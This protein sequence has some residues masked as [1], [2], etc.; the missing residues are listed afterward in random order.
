V[1]TLTL[2]HPETRTCGPEVRY[3][4]SRRNSRSIKLEGSAF[5]G[6]HQPIFPDKAVTAE[7]PNVTIM[8]FLALL[9]SGCGNSL[10]LKPI[11]IERIATQR[12]HNSSN[13]LSNNPAFPEVLT[14]LAACIYLPPKTK[15]HI[16]YLLE[17]VRQNRRFDTVFKGNTT[18]HRRPQSDRFFGTGHQLV[19]GNIF[20]PEL[21][22]LTELHLM[23]QTGTLRRRITPGAFTQLRQYCTSPKKDSG[24]GNRHLGRFGL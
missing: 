3:C 11:E 8:V 4:G 16:Q 5:P 7:L 19:G 20:D 2:T 14:T 1:T 13:W 17:M 24:Q 12:R 18:M 15:K 22:S 21:A 6:K 9:W 10:L 23:I